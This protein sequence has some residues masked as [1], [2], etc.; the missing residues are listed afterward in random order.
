VVAVAAQSSLKTFIVSASWGKVQC[1]FTKLILCIISLVFS[2]FRFNFC[3]HPIVERY[4]WCHGYQLWYP[5]RLLKEVRVWRIALLIQHCMQTCLVYR[6]NRSHLQIII[7]YVTHVP[8]LV[9][10][11]FSIWDISHECFIELQWSTTLFGMCF[12]PRRPRMRPPRPARCDGSR[13]N[14]VSRCFAGDA[15]IV[16]P[17]LAF[18]G[19]AVCRTTVWTCCTPSV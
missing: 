18:V 10:F 19:W 3:N 6:C 17:P 16:C 14:C 15:S 1:C 2:S 12:P 7:I 13:G 4:H 9:H 5:S 11:C 8:K